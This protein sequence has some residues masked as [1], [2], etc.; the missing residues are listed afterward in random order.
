MKKYTLYVD[1]DGVLCDFLKSASEVT[2][3]NLKSSE[4][5]AEVWQESWELIAKEGS[6]FWATLPWTKDGKE[7]W[8][9]ISEYKPNIL[10]AHPKNEANKYH[11]INGKNRWVGRNLSN[12]N[13]IHIVLGIEKQDYAHENAVLI[14][15]YE[16]NILQFRRQGGIGIHHTSTE[17]TITQLKVLLCN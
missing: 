11:A 5:F 15:D 16:R 12:F 2:P 8:N 14:D 9:F 1:M 13:K 4:D 6:S 3:F 7:L 17:S 10:S